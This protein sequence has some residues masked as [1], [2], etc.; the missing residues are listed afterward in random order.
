[1]SVGS[2]PIRSVFNQ[3]G[4]GTIFQF[5]EYKI[6]KKKILLRHLIQYTPES[7]PQLPSISILIE[8]IQQKNKKLSKKIVFTTLVQKMLNMIR[9]IL[10]STKD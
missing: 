7:T 6:I 9:V 10:R 8:E 5:V 2:A 3:L 4:M 1:M